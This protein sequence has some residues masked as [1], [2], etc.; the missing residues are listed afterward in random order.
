MRIRIK[1][2]FIVELMRVAIG[3]YAQRKSCLKIKECF[4]ACA[5][6]HRCKV[7]R[8][9]LGRWTVLLLIFVPKI[10]GGLRVH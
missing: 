6:L 3:A 1:V 4:D 2:H 10:E 7:G 9:K 5:L 8:H